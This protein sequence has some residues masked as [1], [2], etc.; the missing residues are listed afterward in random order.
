ME[1]KRFYYSAVS[2]GEMRC[3]AGKEKKISDISESSLSVSTVHLPARRR[4]YVDA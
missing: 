3:H 4:Y 2:W 1:L